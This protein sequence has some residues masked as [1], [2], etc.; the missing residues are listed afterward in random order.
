M[1]GKDP[2]TLRFQEKGPH[3]SWGSVGESM[4]ETPSCPSAGSGCPFQGP[5]S[6]PGTFLRFTAPLE[7][8]GRDASCPRGDPSPKGETLLCGESQPCASRVRRRSRLCTL[9]PSSRRPNPG[10]GREVCLISGFP[11][12]GGS[13][14][15]AGQEPSGGGE[16]LGAFP[17]ARR[18]GRGSRCLLAYQAT[19]AKLSSSTCLTTCPSAGLGQQLPRVDSAGQWVRAGTEPSHF[20]LSELCS[21]GREARR[22]GGNEPSPRVPGERRPSLGSDGAKQS[23]SGARLQVQ[24]SLTPKVPGRGLAGGSFPPPSSPCCLLLLTRESDAG[25][26]LES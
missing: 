15:P 14:G 8:E 2:H 1:G 22:V 21:L 26:G 20:R 24:T 7:Q 19:K 5:E 18:R 25:K 12:P 11:K 3:G 23:G 4:A 16:S 6:F 10:Q 17:G 9:G 13:Q